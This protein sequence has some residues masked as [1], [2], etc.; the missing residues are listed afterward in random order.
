M[1]ILYRLLKIMDW[2]VA[3]G[4]GPS[5]GASQRYIRWKD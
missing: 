5:E 1:H 4:Q 3:A 2:S